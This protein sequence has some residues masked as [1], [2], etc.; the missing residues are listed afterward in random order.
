MK[1]RGTGTKSSVCL[2]DVA[3]RRDRNTALARECVKQRHSS[4]TGMPGLYST[5][6]NVEGVE[7]IQRVGQEQSPQ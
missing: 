5:A 3:E 2:I 4:Q 1:R 6:R 7:E